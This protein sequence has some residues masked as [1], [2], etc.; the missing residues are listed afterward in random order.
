ML[1]GITDGLLAGK[2]ETG[3]MLMFALLKVNGAFGV[4][5][6]SGL[7]MGKEEKEF[8]EGGCRDGLMEPRSE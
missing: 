7:G 2:V 5:A 4:E 3:P 8:S 1:A 6:V